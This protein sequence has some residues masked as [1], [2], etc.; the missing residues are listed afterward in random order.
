MFLEVVLYYSKAFFW[1]LSA[2]WLWNDFILFN[3]HCH[4][5][6]HFS[7]ITHISLCQGLL[8]SEH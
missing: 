7:V 4:A 8:C 3:F 6:M 2:E 5:C 1:L